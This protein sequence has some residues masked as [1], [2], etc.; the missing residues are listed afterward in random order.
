MH[1]SRDTK[2]RT[3]SQVLYNKRDAGSSLSWRTDPEL[4]TAIVRS[5]LMRR[6]EA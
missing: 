1:V 5:Q 4:L 3:K 2:R 6:N